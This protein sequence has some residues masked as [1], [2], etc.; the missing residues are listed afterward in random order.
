MTR[1]REAMLQLARAQEETAGE[2]VTYRRAR[3]TV[4]LTAVPGKRLDFPYDGSPTST[5]GLAWFF[6]AGALILGGT[7]TAPRDGDTLTHGGQVYELVPL[8]EQPVALPIGGT[9]ADPVQWKAH[10]LDVTTVPRRDVEVDVQTPK[11]TAARNSFG[12]KTRH[13]EDAYNLLAEAIGAKLLPDAVAETNVG[14]KLSGLQRWRVSLAT[15]DFPRDGQDALQAPGLSARLL[16]KT[17]FLG[18]RVLAIESIKR[19]SDNDAELALVCRLTG[20]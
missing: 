7:Q 12:E 3:Q 10:T 2:S 13:A 1:W 14:G 19:R 16:V 8:G 15:R 5:K 20:G 18:G 4:A 11:P 6:R 9:P 17:G